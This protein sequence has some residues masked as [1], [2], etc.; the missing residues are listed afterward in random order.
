MKKNKKVSEYSSEVISYINS[1]EEQFDS[2]S[3]Y[4]DSLKRYGHEYDELSNINSTIE[5][6]KGKFRRS[7]SKISQNRDDDI[8]EKNKKFISNLKIIIDAISP[9]SSESFTI[10]MNNITLDRFNP[11]CEGLGHPLMHLIALDKNFL[12][13][14]SY[15]RFNS[16]Y[17]INIFNSSNHV[18]HNYT[19]K[20]GE[21]NYMRWAGDFFNLSEQY[22]CFLFSSYWK[23][24][25]T[26][27]KKKDYTLEEQKNHFIER[28]K[29]LITSYLPY[30]YRKSQYPLGFS[31]FMEV[32]H[33][34]SFEFIRG[35]KGIKFKNNGTYS[36]RTTYKLVKI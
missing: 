8:L 4:I 7:V 29:W 2:I 13:N 25:T 12:T 26:D 23:E 14:E 9:V 21:I 16:D 20:K 36:P 30:E 28:V 10:D 31:E 34:T 18:Y 35:S 32:L 15:Y 3:S 22:V 5:I 33:N 1:L 6:L 19:P 11:I 17:E 27:N 24:N